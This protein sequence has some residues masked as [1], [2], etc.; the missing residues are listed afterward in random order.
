M[1]TTLLR[2]PLVLLVSLLIGPAAS[3]AGPELEA[4]CRAV[5]REVMAA[6]SGWV[7]IHAAEARIDA[8]EAAEVRAEFLRDRAALER[9]P[10]RIGVWRVLANTAPSPADRQAWIQRIVDV[11]LDPAA[12]DHPQSIETIGKLG[13]AVSGPALELVRAEA[14]RPASV[15]M[16]L[17]VWAARLAGES[18][19]QARLLELLQS[20]QV[21][22]RSDAAYALRWLRPTDL[23]SCA[24]LV[25]AAATEPAASAA[26]PYILGAALQT[27]ADPAQADAWER[28]LETILLIGATDARFEASQTVK[29]RCPEARAA[30]FAPLLDLPPA[31]NDARVG[32]AM[33]ILLSRGRR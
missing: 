24:A 12:P 27:N 13:H 5:L 2:L 25:H 9:L 32:A 1:R 28:E 23:A 17:A 7:K 19:A 16:L 31:Q 30:A 20:P 21:E 6:E 3:G 14:A 18:G 26:R 10:C 29:R 4:R 11:Y 22:L 15:S 33:V 8:G